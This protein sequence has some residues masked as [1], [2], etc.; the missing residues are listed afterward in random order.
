MRPK[1]LFL[2]G[3]PGSGKTT[4]ALELL[5]KEP[6]KYLRVNKD[7]IRQM[8]FGD[9]WTRVNE[10]LVLK[11][12]DRIIKEGL[13]SGLDVI[14]DDTNLNPWHLK[15]V[16]KKFGS[17]AEIKVVDFTDVLL[18]V[19]IDRDKNREWSVGEKEIKK[20]WSQYSSTI[21]GRSM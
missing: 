16:Q 11:I 13:E 12:R 3:L 15:S 4:Y 21:L 1:L 9:R 7:D 5:K 18:Q 8:I 10:P 14:V 19:C 17:L 2:K 20:M 6:K